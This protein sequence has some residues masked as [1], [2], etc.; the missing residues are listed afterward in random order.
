MQNL[1]AY[2]HDVTSWIDPFGLSS[3]DPFILG[4]DLTYFPE[5]MMFS[6]NRIAPKFSDIGS[7]APTSIRGK[8]LESVVESLVNGQI[9]PDDFLISYTKNSNGQILTLN[10]RGLAALTLSRKMPHY[11][12]F[13]PYDRVPSRFKKDLPSNWILVT[14]DK[15]AKDIIMKICR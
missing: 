9:S 1:Y 5:N 3:L 12:V 11:A 7:Q 14:N 10:N 13:I 8:S 4:E 6:Q 2:V 15:A